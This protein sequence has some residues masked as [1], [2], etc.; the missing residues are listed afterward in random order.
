[1]S[2]PRKPRFRYT[3]QVDGEWVRPVRRGFR[4]MCC[5][6]HKVHRVDYRIND[7]QI[8]V[9]CFSDDRATAAARRWFNFKKDADE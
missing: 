3:V 2:K 6:C 8:E 9:R 7:G 5:D 1:M 4:E